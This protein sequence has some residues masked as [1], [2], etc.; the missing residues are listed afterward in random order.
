MQPTFGVFYQKPLE[1]ASFL[2]TSLNQK[3]TREDAAATATFI[4]APV[5]SIRHLQK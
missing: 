2:K 4:I 1:N 5:A 3:Q